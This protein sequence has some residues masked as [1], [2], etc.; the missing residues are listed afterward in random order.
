MTLLLF[1]LL[2]VILG[3]VAMMFIS[4]F[5]DDAKSAIIYAVTALV[6]LV[7]YIVSWIYDVGGGT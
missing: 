3:N 1:I 4:V 7:V 5:R 6:W 2:V